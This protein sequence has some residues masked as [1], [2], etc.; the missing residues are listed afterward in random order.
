MLLKGLQILQEL[1]IRSNIFYISL[2]SH[3]NTSTLFLFSTKIIDT[4]KK[5]QKF[6]CLKHFTHNT[7]EEEINRDPDANVIK[8][9]TAVSYDFS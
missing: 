6:N 4:F 7:S 3:I 1:A 2:C 5:D 8:L 9:F